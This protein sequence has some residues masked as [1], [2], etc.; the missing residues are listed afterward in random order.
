MELKLKTLPQYKDLYEAFQNA[1][2]KISFNFL[3][4]F[5]KIDG[6]I[7]FYNKKL[8]EILFKYAEQKE[9]G[10]LV[11]TDDGA[12]IKIRKDCLVECKKEIDE[13]NELTVTVPDVKFKLKDFEQM[14]LSLNELNL[15]MPFIEDE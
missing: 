6:L 13:L 1:P 7:D 4:I 15:L 10:T 11:L 3:K 9:D 8:N 5:G 14:N 12:G 2:L